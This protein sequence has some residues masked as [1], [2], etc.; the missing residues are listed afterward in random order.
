MGKKARGRAISGLILLD[1]APGE[2]SNASLQKV[3]RLLDAA[4]AGHTGSLDPLATG[5]LPLCFGEATKISQFLLESDK[6]YRTRIRFGVKTETG[7]REGAVIETRELAGLTRERVEQALK[8]F[9][10]EIEQLPSM[11]C[12]LKHQGVPLYKLAREGKTAPRKHRVVT[13]HDIRLL[14]FGGDWAEVAID[15]SKGTYVRTIADD[16]GDMLGV[17]GHV[18]EL[19]RLRAGPFGEE[20]CVSFEAL[21]ALVAEG[22]PEAAD[23]HLIP[24]DEA[25]KDL[26]AVRL[27]A[28]TALYVKQGQPVLARHLPATGLVRLYEAADFIGIGAILDDGRVAPRR[29]LSRG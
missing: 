17:G 7:D 6:V 22:G 13:V 20:A 26:P 19:R 5:V 25:V 21:R 15:C 18:E 23:R 12:A 4:K 28:Q 8:S 9:E 10:G 29:L 2:T 11:Y 16:L 24:C 27:P 1:K 3:K 14:D